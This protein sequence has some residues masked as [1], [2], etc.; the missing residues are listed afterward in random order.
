GNATVAPNLPPMNRTEDALRP[1]KPDQH[2]DHDIHLVADRPGGAELAPRLRRR[3]PLQPRRRVG[4]RFSVAD[5]RTLAAAE[6]I[7]PPG[8]RRHRHLAGNP[9]PDPVFSARPD[10]RIPCL[11]T[12]L[13]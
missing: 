11:T 13:P 12:P 8:S 5:K 4:Q 10:V 3:Q 7:S 6:S 2:G 9:D 1:V